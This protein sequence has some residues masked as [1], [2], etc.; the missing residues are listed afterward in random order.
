MVAV[1]AA[2]PAGLR[3]LD[4]ACKKVVQPGDTLV[5]VRVVREQKGFKGLYICVGTRQPY[6]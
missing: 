4:W 1:D 6:G 5:I 2:D 3:T